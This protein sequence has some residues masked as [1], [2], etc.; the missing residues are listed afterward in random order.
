MI[1]QQ[2]AMS[3]FFTPFPTARRVLMVYHFESFPKAH[4]NKGIGKETLPLGSQRALIPDAKDE[5]QIHMSY[6]W[7][8]SNKQVY[9]FNQDVWSRGDCQRAVKLK[10]KETFYQMTNDAPE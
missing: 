10:D 9:R 5:L 3:S 8:K 7:F 2:A 4:R 1:T 6:K